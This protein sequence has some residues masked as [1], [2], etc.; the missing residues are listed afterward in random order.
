MLVGRS[1]AVA[2]TKWSRKPG[3]I[4]VPNAASPSLTR[5]L[6]ELD[7]GDSILAVRAHVV[8]DDEGTVGPADEHRPVEPQLVD[9]RRHVVGPEPAVGVVLG[10]ERRL[11]HAVAAEVV[12]HQP[13]LVGQRALVLLRPAEMVLRPAVDEQDRRPVRACPTRARAGA[14]RRR[15]SPCGPSSDRSALLVRPLPCLASSCS[16]LS[17]RSWPR[18]ARSASG[19]GLIF[20]RRLRI[21]GRGAYERLPSRGSG[22]ILAG[23]RLARARHSS[24]AHASSRSS[25]ARSTRHRRAA[26]RPSSSPGKRASARPGSR[27]S[28]RHAPATQGSRSCSGARSISSARSCRTSRSS[29]PCARSETLAGRRRTAGSQLRVFEET[30]ALLT[31]RAAAAPVLLVLEDLHWADTSTL[32]LVVFLAHNLDD[33]RVLLLATYRADELA[34]AERVRRL[35]D[36]VRRSGSALLLELGPLERDELT[37]LLAARAD[38]PPPAALTRCDRRPLRG[39]PL[40]R[41]GAPGRRA[42]T[43]GGELPR[44]LRELL[45][46]RVAR[47]DSP[48]ARPAAPGRGGRARRRVP[49][50]PRYG[51]APGARRARVA[52][53]G[54]RARRP[55]R[56]A[57]ERQLPFPPRAPGGGDLLDDPARRARGAAREA[58]GRAR[59][60]R[61][62]VGRRSSRRTGRRRVAAPR[63]SPR[64]SRQHAK[65]RPCSDSPR[66]TRTSSGR[67]RSGTRCRTR[68]SSTGLDLAELCTRAAELASEIGAAARA[69]SSSAGERSSSSARATRTVRPSSM[70][71]SASTSNRPAAKTRASPR[72]NARSSSRRRSRPHRS[73]RIRWGH[74]RGVGSGLAPRGVV[75]DLRSR[76]SRSLGSSAHARRRSGRSRCAAPTS[77]TSAAVRR[78]SPI[79]VRRCS[80]PRRSAIASAWSEH[81]SISPMC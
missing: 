16:S 64:R 32:D 11:G 8:A 4:S 55:R 12:G 29:R 70:C 73:G 20:R 40:L 1:S 59:A 75:A 31:E 24:D 76:H 58:G 37:A 65:R 18:G 33:R 69:R 54:R 14:G 5:A 35:A 61:S 36:G 62:R 7:R 3:P 78:G 42:A 81:G 6:D 53:P 28:S 9:D 50:A 77:P 41:R 49:A 66:L 72:S 47:L 13:E 80:S 63:R 17:T 44:G 15:P 48:D 68:P 22:A 23:W 57:G 60:Q 10:L 21:F 71:A 52:T 74:S 34:S 45:L 38:A 51:G 27:P 19:D 39:Q 2:S 26:A 67:S 79:F 46:Q 30:L 56:R 43:S 25:S